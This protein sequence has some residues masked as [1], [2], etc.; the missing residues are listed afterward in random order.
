MRKKFKFLLILILI[1][2]WLFAGFPVPWQNP[3]IPPQIQEAEAAVNWTQCRTEGGET[4]I[5]ASASSANVTLTT[6]ITDTS[7]AFLLVDSSGASGVSGGDGH[8]V[9]GYIANTTTLTFQRGAAPATAVHITYALVECFNNEFNVQRGEITIAASATQNT[10]AI[11]AVDTTKSIVLVSS[12]TG[13]STDAED[14][15]LATG[16]LQNATTVLV[17]RAVAGT[18]ATAVRYEVVEFSTGSGASIQTNEVTLASGAASVAST[19]T[20]TDFS[21]IR[22]V[23]SSLTAP[24]LLFTVMPA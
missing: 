5:P 17:R 23:A 9:S 22:L 24:R 13:D 12:R 3:R 10:G 6:A 16:E 1:V 19:I 4:T 20:S 21:K 14:E 15:A 11:T 2:S 18:Y 7:Q 8:M